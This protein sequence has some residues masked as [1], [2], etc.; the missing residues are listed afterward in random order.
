MSST[1]EVPLNANPQ[2]MS[3]PLGDKTYQITVRWNVPMNSWS[4]DIADQDGNELVNS[5]P[6]VTGANL[7]EQYDYLEFGG[8]LFAFTDNELDEP[9]TFTNLGDTGH[10]YFYVP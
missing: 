5:I 7:L 3:I 9:P 2:R 6:M 1:F 4:L 10:L 8:D